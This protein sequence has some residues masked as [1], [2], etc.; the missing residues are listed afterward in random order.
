VR[1]GL[2]IFFRILSDLYMTIIPFVCVVDS[3]T[4]LKSPRETFRLL[5]RQSLLCFHFHFQVCWKHEDDL[6]S[7]CGSLGDGLRGHR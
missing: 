5:G 6:R 1:I 2:D 4:N 7:A 3:S